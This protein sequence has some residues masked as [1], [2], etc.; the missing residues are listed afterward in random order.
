MSYEW[1]DQNEKDDATR[2]LY[3]SDIVKNRERFEEILL[4]KRDTSDD[5]RYLVWCSPA[6]FDHD[7]KNEMGAAGPFEAIQGAL[8]LHCD[9]GWDWLVWDLKQ[10]VGFSIESNTYI[11][12]PMNEWAEQYFGLGSLEKTS[13]KRLHEFIEKATT[14]LKQ[15]RE[16]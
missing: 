3:T 11:Y 15:R 7:P 8:D 6:R 12:A 1:E 2:D 4:G 9:G 14:V 5:T 13:S 16:L 10:D